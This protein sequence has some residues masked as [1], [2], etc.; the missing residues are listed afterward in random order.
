[1]YTL[2][3]NLLLAAQ[4]FVALLLVLVVLLQRPRSEGLGTAFAS[5]MVEQYIGPATSVLVR[6][7]TWMGGLFFLLTIALAFLY[8]HQ[9]SSKATIGRNRKAEAAASPAPIVTSSPAVV[10]VPL[11]DTSDVPTAAASPATV[12]ISAPTAATAPVVAP[13]P[14]VAGRG[15]CGQPGGIPCPVAVPR[16][17]GFGGSSGSG[18]AK[19]DG[20][21]GRSAVARHAGGAVAD[22]GGSSGGLRRARCRDTHPGARRRSRAG[23]PCRHAIADGEYQ[24]AERPGFGTGSRPFASIGSDPG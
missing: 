18:H 12:A 20:P 19:S 21:A 10:P 2:L 5:G 16:R 15:A 14:G 6:F 8:A 4:V 22:S 9:Y 11:P 23:G 13:A 24:H 3:I 7:T 1:M 17:A